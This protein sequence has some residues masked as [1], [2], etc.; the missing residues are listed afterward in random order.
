MY[1]FSV[2]GFHEELGFVMPVCSLIEKGE[3]SLIGKFF[4][5]K[6][7]RNKYQNVSC[8]LYSDY[9][10]NTEGLTLER[11]SETRPL[12]EGDVLI[13]CDG[14]AKAKTELSQN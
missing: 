4:K 7:G 3:G 14:D 5:T 11:I 1:K 9:H 6:D 8:T 10:P 13:E 12:K 2:K